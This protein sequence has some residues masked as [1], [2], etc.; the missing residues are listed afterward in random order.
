MANATG[1]IGTS[2][3]RKVMQACLVIG[4]HISG[5]RARG[6]ICTMRKPAF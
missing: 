6:C 1:A 4:I 5:T 2:D 3:F